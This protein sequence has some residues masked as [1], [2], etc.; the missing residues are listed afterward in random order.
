[1]LWLA[2]LESHHCILRTSSLLEWCHSLA[3]VGRGHWEK[4]VLLGD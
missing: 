3:K 2:M 4:I 1:M